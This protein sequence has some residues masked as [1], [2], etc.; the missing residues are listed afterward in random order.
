MKLSTTALV[1]AVACCAAAFAGL[2]SELA[3]NLGALGAFSAE[4]RQRERLDAISATSYH[5]LL[6]REGL[7][8]DLAAGRMS[9]RDAVAQCRGLYPKGFNGPV[10]G[11]SEDERL[12]LTLIGWAAGYSTDEERVGVVL[13]LRDELRDQLGREPCWWESAFWPLSEAGIGPR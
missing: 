8:R 4:A 11:E 9:L 13:R 10:P 6:V 5:R 2:A 3:N 7:A 12:G 1:A